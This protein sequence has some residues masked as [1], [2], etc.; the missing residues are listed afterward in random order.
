MEENQVPETVVEQV[1][2]EEVASKSGWDSLK[3]IEEY[4]PIEQ[5][6]ESVNNAQP[7]QDAAIE[8]KIEP[9]FNENEWFKTKSGGKYEKWEDVEALLNKQTEVEKPSFANETSQKIYEAILN[10]KEDEL[11]DYFS[12]KQFVKNLATQPTE[13]VV[14]AYIQSQI[15]SL[16]Q[17]EV[18]RYY[19]KNYGVDEDNYSD[20]IDLSIAKKEAESKLERVKSDALNYFNSQSE[21]VQLPTFEQQ[22]AVVNGFDAE[23]PINQSVIQF[24]SN[25]AKAISDEIP[26]EYVNSQN[27]A[28]IQGKIPLD[29]KAIS[30]YESA[31]NGNVAAVIAAKYFK[32]DDF[33]SKAFARDQYILDNISEILKG[34]AAKSYN[35][36]VLSKIAKDKNIRVDE[37]PNRTGASPNT[38]QNLEM[39]REYKF[40]GFP[41]D[42]I[43][44]KFGVSADQL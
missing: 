28:N 44:S 9:S 41:L 18:E 1:S 22:Q 37:Q 39:A 8:Q 21:K 11:A 30:E 2:V 24:V 14:K 38:S 35:E 36:G 19:E 26:F 3:P 29:T 20:E 25:K 13:D 43:E 10:G 42:F 12:K 6:E 5:K 34:S 27:G 23:N 32:N 7:T 33:D 31:V 16:T 40:R 4:V 15:P 17:Q